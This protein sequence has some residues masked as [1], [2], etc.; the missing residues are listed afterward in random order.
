MW[1]SSRLSTAA[2]ES[3]PRG[4]Y[5]DPPP[6]G[7]RVQIKAHEL[8]DGSVGQNHWGSWKFLLIFYGC[9]P[10]KARLPSWFFRNWSL[11]KLFVFCNYI[12]WI[13]LAI[14]PEHQL[15]REP[16]SPTSVKSTPRIKVKRYSRER[17]Q[18]KY[19]GKLSNAV[20]KGCYVM[21]RWLVFCFG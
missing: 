19:Y 5:N 18:G 12:Y 14:K 1:N 8:M 9:P 17:E 7:K 11:S 2:R 16:Q 15:T 4:F 10:L 21:N 3:H 13:V 20:V 6:R